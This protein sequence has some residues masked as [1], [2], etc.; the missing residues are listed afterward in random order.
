MYEGPG[1]L[2]QCSSDQF[3]FPFEIYKQ[4]LSALVTAKCSFNHKKK[5][6]QKANLYHACLIQSLFFQVL[7]GNEEILSIGNLIT[8]LLSQLSVP[9]LYI[10]KIKKYHCEPDGHI[11]CICIPNAWKIGSLGVYLV[12]SHLCTDLNAACRVWVQISTMEGET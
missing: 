7:R 8:S 3:S 1:F 2:G 12:S 6:G 9:I 5:I 11:L 4:R 10:R